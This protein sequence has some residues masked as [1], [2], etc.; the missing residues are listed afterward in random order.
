MTR[1]EK[2]WKTCYKIPTFEGTVTKHVCSDAWQASK[3]Q[4]CTFARWQ[5]CDREEKQLVHKQTHQSNVTESCALAFLINKRFVSF[6]SNNSCSFELFNL[7]QGT[8]FFHSVWHDRK[9]WQLLNLG[10]QSLQ[11]FKLK[12]LN[13]IWKS[14]LKENNKILRSGCIWVA[15]THY[16]IISKI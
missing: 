2:M 7:L 6:V 13:Q 10:L 1:G 4:V 3:I 9:K 15:L 12:R 14:R 8:W 11:K 16:F 5:S